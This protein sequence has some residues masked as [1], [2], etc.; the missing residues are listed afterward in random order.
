MSYGKIEVVAPT[1]APIL[2]IVAL[3][4]VD[5]VL[6]PSPKYSITEFVAPLTVNNPASLRMTSLGAVH[7]FNFP[8]K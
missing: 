4:V 3:P 7:P 6:T 5:N 2:H 1:S 8:F